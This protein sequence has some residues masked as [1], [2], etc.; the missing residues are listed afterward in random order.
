MKK[1]VEHVDINTGDIDN[2][3]CYSRIDGDHIRI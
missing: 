2:C 3:A 1:G